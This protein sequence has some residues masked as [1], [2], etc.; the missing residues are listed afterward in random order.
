MTT[1]WGSNIKRLREHLKLSKTQFA[2]DVGVSLAT[3]S[4]WEAG[5]IK[6]IEA[7]HLLRSARRLGVDPEELLERDIGIVAGEPKAR[8]VGRSDTP[9]FSRVPVIGSWVQGNDGAWHSSSSAAPVGFVAFHVS[10]AGAYGLQVLTDSLRPRF[11]PGEV[12]IVEPHRA[13]EGGHEVVALLD[14][15]RML[16][17][18]FDWRR[19]GLV[20]L[21]SVNDDGRPITIR[22]TA[23]HRMERITG[24]VQP[25]QIESAGQ[26]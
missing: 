10:D 26:S 14:D 9:K 11:K 7:R 18:V 3:V 24:A 1:L 19:N 23:V 21:S 15:G 16:A 20:Q 4:D 22:E 6:Q 25:D 2:I 8:Y 13:V 5:K 12:L 17:R